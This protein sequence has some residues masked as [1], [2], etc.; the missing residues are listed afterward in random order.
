MP[1]SKTSMIDIPLIDPSQKDKT[2]PPA[3]T[4]A[5]RHFKHKPIPARVVF[6]R[7]AGP[8]Y[9]PH[10]DDLLSKI[11]PPEFDPHSLVSSLIDKEKGKFKGKASSTGE[12]AMFPPLQKL[13]GKSLEE[14]HHNSGLPAFYGD[15]NLIL[16]SVITT[17]IGVLV[18][19]M[20]SV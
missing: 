13:K 18:C 7:K 2:E 17:F 20:P 3:Q 12:D 1:L 6:S 5:T 8:L 9:L 19:T 4:K 10:L 16:N 11:S 15:K 14:L